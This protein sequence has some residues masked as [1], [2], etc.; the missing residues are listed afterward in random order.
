MVLITR[1]SSKARMVEGVSIEHNSQNR[2]NQT[3]LCKLISH[4]LFLGPK[5]V[6]MIKTIAIVTM[7]KAGIFWG[8]NAI[9]AYP[10][11]DLFLNFG[12]IGHIHDG[13]DFE[14][15]G[16]SPVCR[17]HWRRCNLIEAIPSARPQQFYRLS[18]L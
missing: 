14:R 9:A 3:C 12:N 2:R 5:R 15:T 11:R 1:L 7:T 8:I 18:I 4:K 16:Q 13:R 10:A 6:K 17:T